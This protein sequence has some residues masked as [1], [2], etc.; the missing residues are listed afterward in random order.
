M[1]IRIIKYGAL[2]ALHILL[3]DPAF[4]IAHADVTPFAEGLTDRHFGAFV[5][6][7]QV[8]ARTVGRGLGVHYALRDDRFIAQGVPL[9]QRIGV[10]SCDER[11][12]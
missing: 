11:E 6:G 1:S 9:M 3:F 2:D 4:V 5:E 10:Q 12:E 7:E 8:S